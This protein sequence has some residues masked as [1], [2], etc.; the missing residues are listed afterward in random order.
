MQVLVNGMVI[1]YER[2]GSGPALL[3]VHGWAD[4]LSGFYDIQKNL[5]K[6]YD[7]VAVDLPGFGQSSQPPGPWNLDNYGKFLSEFI[8]KLKI[9]TY[10]L[11]GH[12]N[13]GA[14]LITGLADNNLFAKR[15]VLLGSA[16][17]R[18]K[19]RVKKQTL[20]VVAKSGKALTAM[21]PGSI[22]NNIKQRFYGR[23]G[24][25]Y[26]IAQGMEETFKLVVSQDV[27]EQATKIKVA[28]L[29]IYGREDKSTPVEYG[30]ILSSKI[31][32]SELKV[33]DNAE[34][35]VHSDQPHQVEKLIKEFL[36]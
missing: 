19:Q 28:T 35:F 8:A 2:V 3:L 16:G 1:H 18:D 21:L 36:K 14:I 5:S 27:Q 6:D 20:K 23:I 33:I 15:L 17:I 12:S 32:G 10:G 24:S 11:I 30:E 29:L 31:S 26:L 13:G 4:S 25:D 9:S 22:K 7:V 34:H